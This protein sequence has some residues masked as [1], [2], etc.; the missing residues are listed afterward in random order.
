MIAMTRQEDLV[1]SWVGADS[2][3]RA[4]A[5][6]LATLT[7]A[8]CARAAAPGMP[9][10]VGAPAAGAIPGLPPGV[11]TPANP[12][13]TGFQT[14]GVIEGFYGVPWSHQD[15]LDMLR[16]LGTVGLNTYIYAPKD[17]PYHRER[18]R[19]PYPPADLARVAEL[20]RVGREAGVNVWFAVSPGLSMTYASDA[21]YAALLAKLDA[22]HAVG[23]RA[24]GL[25]LDDVPETLTHP[26]DQARFRSLAAAH[27]FVINR[28][29][30]D[31]DAR[32]VALLVVQTAYTNVFGSRPYLDELA[33]ALPPSV[34]LIWTGTDV[35]P[36]AMTAAAAREWGS[37]IRRKPLVWDNYPVNDFLPGRLFLGPIT[38]RA[39]DLESAVDGYV[40]NPMNQ[41]HASM[42]PLW[43]IADYLRHPGQYDPTASRARALKALY[44][45]SRD[46]RKARQGIAAMTTFADAY[47]T[48]IA[49][50]PLAPLLWPVRAFD[51]TRAL[52]S[53]GAMRAA[54]DTMRALAGDDSATWAPL[55]RELSPF[56]DSAAA[57]LQRA[58]ADTMYALKG[59]SLVF[60]GELDR[61]VLPAARTSPTVD[62]VFYDWPD[63]TWRPMARPGI[64]PAPKIALTADSATLYLALDVPDTA[65]SAFPGDSAL[66]GDH[67]E[68][69]LADPAH[70]ETP[71]LL[72]ATPA[73]AA[74]PAAIAPWAL[75]LSPFFRPLLAAAPAIPPLAL[76]YFKAPV[77]PAFTAAAAAA[78]VAS[79]RDA[80]RWQI[81][82]AIPRSGL[83]V[84]RG[85]LG[86]VLRLA[87]VAVPA[88]TTA[89]TVGAFAPL[90]VGTL[91][92]RSRPLNPAT[93]TEVVLPR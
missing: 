66:V 87:V 32:G 24:V 88:T 72:I 63:A 31:L 84:T 82:M 25:F 77:P 78:R 86:D 12:V 50:G 8:A 44:G 74:R 10:P 73:T 18:W 3:R 75:S 85:P 17:D 76:A 92:P 71:L 53:A 54:L 34:P 65:L 6:A 35:R 64:G 68:I 51:Y 69:A 2:R 30:T 14:R 42:L 15:R 55:V 19:E 16:F 47:P 38:G 91:S 48:D 49:S 58:R 45:H 21:D 60:R 56:A 36:V 28:L 43:T 1:G 61:I 81:E 40:A 7:L 23:V 59:D 62:A 11:G 90:T 9:T 13:G 89:P 26:E 67:V 46:A 93:Y 83:P 52:A 5:L 27:A 70:E 4:L 57:R 80:Q 29:K 20:V 37:W 39:T 41:A 22:V 79:T 33:A